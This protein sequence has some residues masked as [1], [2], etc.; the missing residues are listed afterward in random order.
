MSI[1]MELQNGR[2]APAAIEQTDLRGDDCADEKED[3][4][5]ILDEGPCPELLGQGDVKLEEQVEGDA[6]EPYE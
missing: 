1:G 3:N 6:A 5:G 2:L 4:D